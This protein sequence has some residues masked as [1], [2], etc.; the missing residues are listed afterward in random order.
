LINLSEHIEVNP[1]VMMGKPVIKVTRTPLDS[2][3]GNWARE[4]QKAICWMHI[5]E[6]LAGTYWPPSHYEAK[7]ANKAFEE[8]RRFENAGSQAR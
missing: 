2:F 1:E 8:K 3:C 6:S 4:F 5:R 7:S